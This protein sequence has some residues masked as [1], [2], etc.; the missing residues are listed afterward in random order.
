MSKASAMQE[1]IDAV[2]DEVTVR[3]SKP[4]EGSFETPA[5]DRLVEAITTSDALFYL[6]VRDIDAEPPFRL[7]TPRTNG[8]WKIPLL[9]LYAARWVFPWLSFKLLSDDQMAMFENWARSRPNVVW[10]PNA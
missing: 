6:G 9:D 1:L 5:L 3:K 10:V 7:H 8:Y 2:I 4:F